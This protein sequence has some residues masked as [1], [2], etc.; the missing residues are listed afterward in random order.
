M[1][2]PTKETYTSLAKVDDDEWEQGMALG[3]LAAR[4]GEKVDDNP[5]L[6]RTERWKGWDAGWHAQNHASED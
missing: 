4:Y 5:H 3:I 1:T 2:S 6:E